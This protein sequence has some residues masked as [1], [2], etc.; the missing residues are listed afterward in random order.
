MAQVNPYNKTNV[1]ITPADVKAILKPYKIDINVN[2]ISLYVKAFTDESYRKSFYDKD[3]VLEWTREMT[4]NMTAFNIV[5]LQEF[6]YEIIEFAGDQFIKAI[7]VDYLISRYDDPKKHNQGFLTTLKSRLEN[8]SEFST[9]ARIMGLGSFVLISRAVEENN[10]RDS[11]KILEDVFEAFIYAIYK[12]QGLNGWNTINTLITNF[13]DSEIDYSEILSCDTNYIKRLQDFHTSNNWSYP[14]YAELNEQKL[15]E[16]T[17]YTVA[18]QTFDGQVL[19]CTSNTSTN[20]KAAKFE[21][22][23]LALEYYGVL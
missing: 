6:D 17:F 14:V 12:D 21:A 8:T 10:G 9:F 16:K 3:Q 19:D 11:E 2:D 22:A 13:L 5:P 23:K 4:E 15:N 1:L 20:I 7:M 18:V